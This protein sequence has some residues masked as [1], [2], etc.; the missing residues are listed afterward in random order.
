MQVTGWL[1][2]HRSI[3]NWQWYDNKPTLVI[4]IHLLLSAVYRPY[5]F[6]GVQLFPGQYIT[7]IRRL[8]K[9]TGY[10]TKQVRT[11]LK[12]LILSDN[13]TVD[14]YRHYS[15]ITIINYDR[16]QDTQKPDAGETPPPDE[17]KQSAAKPEP[18]ASWQQIFAALRA[19]NPD[20]NIFEQ[21][22]R[23]KAIAAAAKKES[24]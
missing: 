7:S 24:S 15:I 21:T 8:A 16:Y 17:N 13:I 19:K 10:T 22:T 18:A 20:G 11:A 6:N 9:A 4:Y 3:L 14:A 23:A 1:K 12:H 2:L 5:T